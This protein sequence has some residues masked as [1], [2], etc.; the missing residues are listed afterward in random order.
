VTRGPQR[1]A[2]A[3]LVD[4]ARVAG[5]SPQ[6]VSNVMGDRTG[7]TE[8]TRKRVLAAA[9]ELGYSPNRAAQRLRTRR[10]RQLGLHLPADQL[11]VRNTF[12]ISFLRAATEAAEAAEHQLVVFTTPLEERAIKALVRSGVDGFILCNVSQHDGRPRLFTEMGLPFA[13]MGRLDPSVPQSCVDIDNVA[14]MA[15]VVDHLVARGCRTFGYVGY[16]GTEYWEHDR[17]TGTRAGLRHHGLELAEKWTVTGLP[18]VVGGLIGPRLLAGDTPDAV[19]C[20]SD[21]LAVLVHGAA[22]RAGLEPG[23][24]VA[25]TGFDGLP[26]PVDLEPPLTSV[27]LPIEEAA[28]AVIDLLVRQIEGAAAPDRGLILPTSLKLGGTT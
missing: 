27:R 10:S 2:G 21:S 20:G 6:T 12:S 9:A 8:E 28:A 11:T 23:R 22:V 13:L 18:A 5:V 1:G 16:A 26:L 25:L 3:R 17:L 14:A 19:I 15:T 4:V 7:F 24:D